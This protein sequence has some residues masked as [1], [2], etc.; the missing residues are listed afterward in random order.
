[1]IH[2]AIDGCIQLRNQYNLTADKIERIELRVH[3]LVL[4]LTGKKTPQTGL[5]GKFSVYYAA[6]AAI[7]E[8]AAGEKQFSD[9]L[10]HD[11]VMTALR[12]RVVAVVDPAIHEEQVRVAITLKDGTRLEKFVEHA[13]G[14]VQRP[15]SDADLEMKFTGLVEGILPPEKSRQLMDLCRRA[16]ELPSAA[17]LAKA[18]AA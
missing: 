7:V 13:V 2:P 8:G 1:V 9:R 6:A 17:E 5:E 11:P 12:D 3:P 18:A 15:M 14:S 16:E 4:E 10:V